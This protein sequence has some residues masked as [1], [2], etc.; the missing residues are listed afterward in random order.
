MSRRNSVLVIDDEEHILN[1]LAYNLQLDGLEVYLAEDG[2]TGLE[3]VREKKPDVIVLDWMM[4]EMDGLE[5]LSEL[6]KDEVTKD[7]PV[8]M[9]TCKKM[10]LDVGQALYQ[11]AADYILKPFEPEELVE[12]VRRK[13][14][15]VVKS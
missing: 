2:P 9:L 1:I 5:V 8:I 14:E 12:I 15:S 4:P 10:M 6:G 7:I 3:I 13:L 11:G